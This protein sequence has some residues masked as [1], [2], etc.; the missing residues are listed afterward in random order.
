[1]LTLFYSV[2]GLTLKL[3]T[4]EQSIVLYASSVQFLMA[5]TYIILWGIHQAP[6]AVSH[7][8]AKAK[9]KK[10]NKPLSYLSKFVRALHLLKMVYL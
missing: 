9:N 4:I 2:T 6:L 7:L 3:D 1:M 5:L 10:N 8:D